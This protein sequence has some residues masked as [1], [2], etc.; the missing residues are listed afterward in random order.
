MEGQLRAGHPDVGGLC[1]ALV[2]WSSELRLLQAAQGTAT[3]GPR[4]A[5]VRS[6]RAGAASRPNP[7]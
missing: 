7:Q 2:D 6:R 4:L 1:R 3:V 5:H